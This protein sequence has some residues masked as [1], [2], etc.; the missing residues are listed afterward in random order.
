MTSATTP[1][2]QLPNS[3]T[4]TA[5]PSRGTCAIKR[6]QAT[7][8]TRI[9]SRRHA[10]E[11]PPHCNHERTRHTHPSTAGRFQGAW[12][13]ML[14]LESHVSCGTCAG[15]GS[16]PRARESALGSR[17]HGT[18]RQSAHGSCQAQARSQRVRVRAPPLCTR[19]ATIHSSTTRRPQRD[20]PSPRL[21]RLKTTQK[22]TPPR[23]T[24]RDARQSAHPVDTQATQT[25]RATPRS[26]CHGEPFAQLTPLTPCPASRTA[27]SLHLL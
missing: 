13:R 2:S 19:I 16:P 26:P 25:P 1:S 18:T 11:R 8:S 7:V 21:H 24:N 15:C 4:A 6:I 22:H 20:D 10:E 14:K 5:Q 23:H 27:R 12:T 9:L 17:P 3:R